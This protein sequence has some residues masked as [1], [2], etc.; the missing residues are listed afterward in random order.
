MK[1]FTTV[2]T[3][4]RAYSDFEAIEININNLIFFNQNIYSKKFEHNR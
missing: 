3:M 1:I 2:A 4:M